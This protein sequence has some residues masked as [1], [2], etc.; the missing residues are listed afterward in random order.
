VP[1]NVATTPK[2]HLA[3]GPGA[4]VKHA[5]LTL[6]E[7]RAAEKL[8]ERALESRV[9]PDYLPE[10]RL[11]LAILAA[12]YSIQQRARGKKSKG[13]AKRLAELRRGRVNLL[14][15][16]V[17]DRKY[18]QKPTAQATVMKMIERLD[19]TGIEG[20]ESQVRRDIHA[21]LKLGPLPNY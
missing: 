12:N 18:R 17:V 13:R 21:A 10:E 14:L 4:N 15:R 5:E 9:L 11:V 7:I 2:S 1:R 3:A 6:D 16:Y 20:S 19:E 8:I